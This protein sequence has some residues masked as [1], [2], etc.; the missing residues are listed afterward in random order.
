M[1]IEELDAVKKGKPAPEGYMKAAVFSEVGKIELQYKSIPKAGPGEIVIK[2]TS[3]TICGTDIHIL[4]GEH[5]VEENRTLGHEHVGI[6][7][8]I[9]EGVE[10][11]QIGERVMCGS[12]TPCGSC[13][14]CQKNLPSQCV[15]PEGNFETPGGWRL[16][17]TIDGTHA[18]YFKMPFP[19]YNLTR[20]PNSLSD[21]QVLLLT[22]I[23]STGIAAAENAEI[24]IGDIVVVFACGPVGLCAIAG[25]RLKGASLIVGVDGNPD[26]LRIAKEMGAD[27][28]LNFNKVNVV[29]EIFRF[30][31]GRG[32]DVAIE[33]LGKQET[34]QNCL[35]VIRRGGCISSVGVYSGHLQIPIENFAGGMGDHRIITTLCPGGRERM[36]QL[37]SLVS[38]NRINLTPM[39]THRFHIDEVVEAYEIFEHAKDNVIKI[40]INF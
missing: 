1:R 38:G 36:N 25:A 37:I 2:T 26:R 30:S 19:K 13:Y 34:F 20:I 16:G 35:K 6:V 28:T 22:D 14:Y 3:T 33:A 8:E 40:V 15:G 17:N 9:G 4:L 21:D 7:Y 11:I 27:I 39:I 10:G 23:G 24:Q 31:Q 29:E 32:A 18:E 12:C 5:P